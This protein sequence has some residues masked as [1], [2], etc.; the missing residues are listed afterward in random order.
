MVLESSPIL[1]PPFLDQTESSVD[2]YNLKPSENSVQRGSQF[3]K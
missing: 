1:Y 2:E 3:R